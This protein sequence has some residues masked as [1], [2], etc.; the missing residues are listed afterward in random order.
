MFNIKECPLRQ[1]EK[2]MNKPY[3]SGKKENPIP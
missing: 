2:K 3:S 1:D